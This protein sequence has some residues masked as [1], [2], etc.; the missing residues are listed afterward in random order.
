[1]NDAII[2]I[3]FCHA[4]AHIKQ[5]MHLYISTDD[6]VLSVSMSVTL[7]EQLKSLK[8]KDFAYPYVSPA[9]RLAIVFLN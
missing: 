8:V 2:V 9:P 5:H 3:I 6:A 7:T 4:Y 1:M